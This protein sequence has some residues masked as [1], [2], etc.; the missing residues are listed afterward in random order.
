[1]HQV[2]SRLQGCALG[3]VAA[4]PFPLTLHA[5]PGC[6]HQ[7]LGIGSH[8]ACVTQLALPEV[9]AVAQP[10]PCHQQPLIRDHRLA[11]ELPGHSHILGGHQALEGGVLPFQHHQA[12]QLCDYL[13]HPGDYSQGIGAQQWR[14][15]I[16]QNF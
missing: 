11:V 15:F 12:L 8:G 13:H 6:A 14:P 9:E 5:Q 1:M 2:S 10:T 16:L 4:S 3:Y 7:P